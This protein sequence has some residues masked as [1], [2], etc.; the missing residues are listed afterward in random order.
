M[1]L[2]SP[3]RPESLRAIRSTIWLISAIANTAGAL[4]TFLY[5]QAI[6]PMPAGELSVRTVPAPAWLFFAGL[7]AVTFLVGSLVHRRVFG[8]LETWSERLARGADPAE[9]PADV[10]RQALDYPWQDAVLSFVIW[11]LAAFLIVLWAWSFGGFAASMPRL[12]AGVVGVGGVL[13]TA[14]F[15]FSADLVWR[16]AI[17]CFFADGRLS[18]TPGF[19]LPVLGRLLI[20]LLLIGLWPLALLAHLSIQRARALA[21]APNPEAILANLVT[22]EI[23]VVGVALAAG[24]GM[25]VFLT[26]SIVGPLQT[27]QAAM[28][29]VEQGDLAVAVPVTTSDELGYLAERFN[30]MTAGLRQGELLRTLLNLYVSPE[31]AREVVQHGARLGGRLVEC[32]VL[33]SDIRDFTGLSERLPAADL[34]ALLN[35]YMGA[36]VAVVVAEGGMVNKFGGDSL[37]AVFGTPLN[38]AEDHAA[39]AVRCAMAMRRALADFNRAQTESGG[40]TLRIGV[41]IATGPAIAGNVGGSERIEYTVIGDTVNLASR[42]QALTKD[43]G[44]DV[45]VSAPTYASAASVLSI[46]GTSLPAVSVRGKSEPVAAYALRY[47]PAEGGA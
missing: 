44:V 47:S 11:L 31:V 14:I 13:T 9:V 16:R 2:L 24:V 42:L 3:A 36:V 26:R 10:R 37:L 29:R 38:P 20:V 25:A 17:P 45:L 35:R 33:F 21:G 28:A 41:G 23:F 15:Y 12:L 22:L 30:A 6:D 7:M 1:I 27:L 8:R 32:S 46:E 5:F 4:L 18:S 40:P 34:I 39:R 43:L 19:R